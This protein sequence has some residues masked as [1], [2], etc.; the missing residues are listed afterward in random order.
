M[1]EPR[2]VDR[3][4][5]QLAAMLDHAAGDDPEGFAQVV[6]LLDQAHGEGLRNAAARLRQPTA[7][8]PGYS[9]ADLARPLGVTRDGAAKR[10]R[11]R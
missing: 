4:R 8:A 2:E 5:R 10:F 9:W 3:W 11:A 6:E 1:F 7:V